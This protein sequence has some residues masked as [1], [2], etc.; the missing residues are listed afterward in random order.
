MAHWAEAGVAHFAHQ[1][2]I[3]R[4]CIVAGAA[5]GRASGRISPSRVESI[6]R[7]T[8][9]PVA[10]E[11][12]C[13]DVY[14]EVAKCC[15]G[16]GSPYAEQKLVLA[17]RECSRVVL[18]IKGVLVELAIHVR[19]WLPPNRL[20]V[21]GGPSAPPGKEP[22]E[23]RAEKGLFVAVRR[24][25]G[26]ERYRSAELVELLRTSCSSCTSSTGPSTGF[27]GQGSA[28]SPVRAWPDAPEGMPPRGSQAPHGTHCHT[29]LPP[30]RIGS[31]PGSHK[32]DVA[33]KLSPE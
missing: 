11:T 25:H 13:E 20:A 19:L 15:A 1:A 22:I 21:K 18:A 31:S 33:A 4:G 24:C 23:K 5:G 10:P 17:L 16:V 8:H 30:L 29:S 27:A 32:R 6:S 9:R 3:L 7:P 14:H 28:E 26:C 2:R 12:G